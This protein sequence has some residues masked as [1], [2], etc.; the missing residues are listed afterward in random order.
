MAGLSEF[1]VAGAGNMMSGNYGNLMSRS[2]VNHYILSLSNSSQTK[3]FTFN[4]D[5]CL[6]SSENFHDFVFSVQY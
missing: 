5:F 3:K 1:L 6:Q 4:H 2:L